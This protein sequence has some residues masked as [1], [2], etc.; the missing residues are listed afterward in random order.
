MKDEKGERYNSEKGTKKFF[1]KRRELIANVNEK[2]G[3]VSKDFESEEEES[4]FKE[5]IG[6]Q[7]DDSELVLP[8]IKGYKLD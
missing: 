6:G 1:N 2:L 3:F 7:K 4:S 5:L 8:P